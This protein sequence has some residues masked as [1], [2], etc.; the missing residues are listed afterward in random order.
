VEKAGSIDYLKLIRSL[1]E[2]TRNQRIESALAILEESS[3]EDIPSG[4]KPKFADIA[5]RLNRPILGLK[6]LWPEIMQKGQHSSDFVYELVSTLRRLGLGNQT[7]LWLER[8][9]QSPRSLLE[10]AFFHIQQ[11]EYK[12]A[13]EILESLL[14][15]KAAL[16]DLN[17]SILQVNLM[18]CHLFNNEPAKA[19]KVQEDLQPGLLQSH[20]HLYINS[21]ELKGQALFSLRKFE[22]SEKVLEEAKQLVNSNS[23]ITSL[24]IQKWTLILKY[25]TGK[26]GLDDPEFNQIR[27][28]A[29][30]VEN[31]ETIRDLDYQ[32]SLLGNNREL[33]IKVLF[34]TPYVSYKARILDILT[35]EPIPTN[36][37][38]HDVRFPVAETKF[39]PLRFFHSDIKFGQA[40]HRLICLLLSDQYRPYSVIRLFDL[41]FP[42]ELY[43]P[44]T[45][46]GRIHNLIGSTRD[47]LRR[48]NL[49][50]DIHSTKSG[51]RMR[52]SQDVSFVISHK[53]I[54]Q[55]QMDLVLNALRSMF[56]TQPFSR[57][58]AEEKLPFT[59]NQWKRILKDLVDSNNL[60]VNGNGKKTKY[61]IAS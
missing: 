20:R 37:I 42:D 36:Y 40:E 9:P 53:M 26:I 46:N 31:W 54:F 15:S 10:R 1:E 52:P 34:G 57:V 50:L 18:A 4:L 58:D 2:E 56:L 22:S 41:L 27:Q 23:D 19:L 39:D 3:P 49:P 5:R 21:L 28:M 30:R 61:R 16:G 45:S 24:L 51:Y 60:C 35:S 55:D 43:N 14:G 59:R 44:Y 38:W 29:R 13:G 6:I 33:M 47:S 8:I 12:E 7:R 17:P 48:L 25:A 11:W 32:L